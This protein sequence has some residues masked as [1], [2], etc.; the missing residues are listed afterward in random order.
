MALRFKFRFVIRHDL[1]VGG[2]RRY[3][4]YFLMSCHSLVLHDSVRWVSCLGWLRTQHCS[5]VMACEVLTLGKAS[6][7][8]P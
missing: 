4:L 1:R 7:M 8:G 2:F 5:V 6:D 3:C